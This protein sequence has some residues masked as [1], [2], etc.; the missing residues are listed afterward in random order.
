MNS[1]AEKYLQQVRSREHFK[2][3]IRT[4][5]YFCYYS[6][7][8]ISKKIYYVKDHVHKIGC[9]VPVTQ[10]QQVRYD[11]EFL[12]CFFVTTDYFIFVSFFPPLF[13][14]IFIYVAQ[15][16]SLTSIGQKKAS[17]HSLI[18]NRD[19]CNRDREKSSGQIH[20]SNILNYRSHGQNLRSTLSQA[21][22]TA[23]YLI[24]NRPKPMF[25]VSGAGCGR[26]GV[27]YFIYVYFPFAYISMVIHLHCVQI[28]LSIFVSNLHNQC[29]KAWNSK[30]N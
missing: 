17:S 21:E 6:T 3:H 12:Q 9:S 10:D 22:P 13:S 29:R 18:L 4:H 27:Q 8:A 30:Q 23:Q 7:I 26:G 14:L 1:L 24:Q 20:L 11:S 2:G 19:T 25:F 5:P 15:H 16:R 28:W